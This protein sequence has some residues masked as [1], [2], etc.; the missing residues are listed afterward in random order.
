M[1]KRKG[2]I[3]AK[4]SNEAFELLRSG[5]C[6]TAQEAIDQTCA[7]ITPS[8]LTKRVKRTDLKAAAP[9]ASSRHHSRERVAPAAGLPSRRPAPK[10]P[11][12]GRGVP[13][14]G[15]RRNPQQASRKRKKTHQ[16]LQNERAAANEV[17]SLAAE[18]HVLQLARL[19][20]PRRY[21]KT[22]FVVIVNG[23]RAYEKIMG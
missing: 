18:R 6:K 20:I 23:K 4:E 7:G 8:A 1:G 17:L 22:Y 5:Q 2:I 15:S 19:Y 11:A 21:H 16:K 10:M 3:P 12:P 14:D 13:I 9:A